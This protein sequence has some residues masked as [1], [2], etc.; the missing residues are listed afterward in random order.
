MN[1]KNLNLFYV[2]IRTYFK[3]GDY[4]SFLGA[5]WSFLG[6]LMTFLVM[7]F[8]F[9]DRFGRQIP[10]FPVFLL[11]S[12]IP[13]TFFISIVNNTLSFLEKHRNILL[14]SKT[15]PE[16]LLLASL[17]TP[18][19]KFLVEITLCMLLA[20]LAGTFNP[21]YFP[22][23]IILCLLFF[24]M[25]LG[26]GMIMAILKRSAGDIQEIWQILSRLLLF[27]TPTFYTLDMLSQWGRSTVLL[28]NPLTPFILS[29]QSIIMGEDVPYFGIGTLLQILVYS[30]GC[31]IIGYSW[32]KHSEVYLA[33]SL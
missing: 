28:L 21:L 10:Y 2:L 32:F 16:I 17:T 9:R 8:I 29:F 12:I 26:T 18:V 27:V 3:T 20:L 30:S 25:S 4:R 15:P 6:P 24:F 22:F 13:L 7:Y 14:N 23:L 11:A 31:F 19:L 33:E 1:K 5:F